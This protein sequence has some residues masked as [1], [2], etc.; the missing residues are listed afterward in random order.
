MTARTLCR[1]ARS[2][3][4]ALIWGLALSSGSCKNDGTAPNISLVG[5]WDLI[6]FTDAGVAA[7][8][9]GTWSFVA[10]GSFTVRGTVT[11]PGEPTDSLVV[12]GNYVQQRSSVQLTIGAQT[13]AWTITGN[14]VQVVLTET[15]PPPANTITLRRP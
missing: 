11:F 1:G 14:S 8:T 4:V 2:S 13:G 15:E 9:T 5:T 7:V 6:G 12:S 3:C 10:D